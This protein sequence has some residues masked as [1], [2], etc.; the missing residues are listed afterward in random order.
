MSLAEF[1][2]RLAQP[3]DLL[4]ELTTDE[5]TLRDRLAAG[6]SDLADGERR[7][8]RR[9][10]S[11]EPS[12]FTL[13]Q[14]ATALAEAPNRARRLVES[15]IETRAVIPPDELATARPMV[16]EV[17]RLLHCYLRELAAG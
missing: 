9:L 17:P 5:G 1:A 8:L 3:D 13:E 2:A 12:R 15:L 4:T 16:Y 11:L 14:A 10:G 6:L 7:A